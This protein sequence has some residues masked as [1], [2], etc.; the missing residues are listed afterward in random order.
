MKIWVILDVQKPL[1]KTT[2]I[3]K[4]GGETSKVILKYEMLGIFCYLC[5]LMDHTDNSCKKLLILTEDDGNKK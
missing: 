4:L 2:K 3:K 1:K 5:G